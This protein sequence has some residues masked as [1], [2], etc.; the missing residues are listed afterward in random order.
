VDAGEE[1]SRAQ[2]WDITR[3]RR[4]STRHRKRA[5]GPRSLRP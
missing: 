2:L 3:E 4:R 5:G 1:A